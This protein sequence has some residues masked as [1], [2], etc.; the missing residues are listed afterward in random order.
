MGDVNGSVSALAHF[1]SCASLSHVSILG[2][3][4]AMALSLRFWAFAAPS[5][6]DEIDPA[7]RERDAARVRRRTQRRGRRIGPETGEP[8][9]HRGDDDRLS[10]AS[11]GWSVGTLAEA[12]DSNKT[13]V[14]SHRTPPEE[15]RWYGAMLNRVKENR[16][17]R[18]MSG[19]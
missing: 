14:I 17:A 2:S 1:A 16:P 6:M 19:V 18:R 7:A 13:D 3:S 5:R 15:R 4:R 10:S 11:G 12:C 8:V 9:D